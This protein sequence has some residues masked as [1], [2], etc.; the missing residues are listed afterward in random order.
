MTRKGDT[1][2]FEEIT[3]V[4]ITSITLSPPK[5]SVVQTTERHQRRVGTPGK[6]Y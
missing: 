5:T 1:K 6:P 3:N 4:R 2:Y